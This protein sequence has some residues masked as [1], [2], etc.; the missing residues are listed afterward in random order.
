[1]T[2]A[3]WTIAAL[4]ALIALPCMA[5]VHDPRV[6][7]WNP[8]LRYDHPYAGPMVIRKV[9]LARIRRIGSGHWAMS[10]YGRGGACIVTIP[11]DQGERAARNTLR[12]ER[13]HCNGWRGNHPS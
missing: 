13:G 11:S 3:S 10:K 9:P 7:P 4:V 8:P 5:A 12:H 6:R 2:V 1:M